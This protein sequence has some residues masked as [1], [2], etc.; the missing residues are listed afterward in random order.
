MQELKF[1]PGLMD[2]I[3]SGKKQA[4][5][6]KG[7][8]DKLHLGPIQFQNNKVI[9]DINTNY[10]IYKIEIICFGDITEEL[11]HLEAY[12][13]SEELKNT[14]VEIYGPLQELDVMTVIYFEYGS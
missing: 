10:S 5:T 14:L 11:A 13:N 12:N 1:N 8:K 2:L 4:T 6:R 7:R 9:E 3:E